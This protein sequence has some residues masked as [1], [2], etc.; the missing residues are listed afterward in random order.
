[1]HP[2][3]APKNRFPTSLYKKKREKRRK[4]T[5]NI[6]NYYKNP[7]LSPS[8]NHTLTSET[9]YGPI[10]L[11]AFASTAPPPTTATHGFCT[12]GAATTRSQTA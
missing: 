11:T 12:A 2:N 7:P 10:T 5:K 1:M 9:I 4:N 6:T 3:A 8:P